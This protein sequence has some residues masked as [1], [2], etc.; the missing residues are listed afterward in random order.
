MLESGNK[1]EEKSKDI[2]L[3]YVNTNTKILNLQKH[4]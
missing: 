4:N 2:Y 1:K 3:I